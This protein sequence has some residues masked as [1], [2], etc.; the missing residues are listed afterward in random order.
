MRLVAK[1]RLLI[2]SVLLLFSKQCFAAPVP[3]KPIKEAIYLNESA[4]PSILA[5]Q[6]I[7]LSPLRVKKPK[8]GMVSAPPDPAAQAAVRAW[9]L[10]YEGMKW[11]LHSPQ[12]LTYEPIPE[13]LPT[14][15]QMLHPAS[16]LAL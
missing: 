6:E 7:V 10:I 15:L 14:S 3:W 12:D 8:S 11:R 2:P 9:L 1:S 16:E 13:R 4:S 5:P